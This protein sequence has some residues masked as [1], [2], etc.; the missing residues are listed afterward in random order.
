MK[1]VMVGAGYVGL[2]YGTCFAETGVDVACVDVD[3]DKIEM[4]KQGKTCRV[5]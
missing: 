4:L 3:L 5:N 1:I 2:V